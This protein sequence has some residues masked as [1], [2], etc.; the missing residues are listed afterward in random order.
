MAFSFRGAASTSDLMQQLLA[1][2]AFARS[3]SEHSAA[4]LGSLLEAAADALQQQ[5]AQAKVQRGLAIAS[6]ALA[7][8]LQLKIEQ[9]QEQL[10]A[11]EVQ[12]PLQPE[13]RNWGGSPPPPPSANYQLRTVPSEPRARTPRLADEADAIASDEMRR[14]GPR[15][16]KT[17]V[18]DPP[19]PWHGTEQHSRRPGPVSPGPEADA[20]RAVEVMVDNLKSRFE[21]S[22][23]SLPLD[24]HT[25]CVY[26]LGNRK[27]SLNI[28]N[29]RLMVRV[30][31]GFCDFL[32]YLSK[33]T[34]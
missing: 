31:G 23:V 34:L 32:E 24:K 20:E 17:W 6:Q 10:E 11:A 9:L 25:G 4:G 2:A 1:G 28:R 29:S 5:C 12:Q 22:G 19:Q 16:F 3:S 26:R 13:S 8:E 14:L 33:A 18:Q 7:A 21:E 27:L 30:G 15:A